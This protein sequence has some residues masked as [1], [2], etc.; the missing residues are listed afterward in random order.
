MSMK[1]EWPV[2]TTKPFSGKQPWEDW[3]DQFETI[4]TI[5][6]W[7]NEQKLIWL[8]VQL[9]GRALWHSRSFR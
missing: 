2:I 5:N 4:A 1:T 9:T 6:G 7:N 3:I 8:K